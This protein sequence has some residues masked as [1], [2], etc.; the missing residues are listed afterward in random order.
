MRNRLSTNSRQE[1]GIK[2]ATRNLMRQS[3]VTRV[4]LCFCVCSHVRVRARVRARVCVCVCAR[5]CARI[6]ACARSRPRARAR[7]DNKLPRARCHPRRVIPRNLG[8][9][10]RKRARAGGQTCGRNKTVPGNNGGVRKPAGLAGGRQTNNR[11]GKARLE[12]RLA[13]TQAGC[14]THRRLSELA[15][16][17]EILG[18]QLPTHKS[19]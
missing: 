5:V 14:N 11:L 4:A 1:G 7:P 8:G 12:Q 10:R 6:D 19:G 15:P 2:C 13:V 3:M 17:Q 18:T 9:A 16:K